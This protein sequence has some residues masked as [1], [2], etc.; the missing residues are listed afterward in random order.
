[1]LLFC[2]AHKARP[3]FERSEPLLRLREYLHSALDGTLSIVIETM[4]VGERKI[5]DIGY[6]MR[7]IFECYRTKVA[8][9]AFFESH[10][11]YVDFQLVVSGQERF[12]IGEAEDCVVQAPYDEERDLVVYVS[13][14][15]QVN[16]QFITLCPRSLAIFF[17]NDVHAGG[18]QVSDENGDIVHKCVIK[19]PVGLLRLEL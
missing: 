2:D 6:G 19:V 15:M 4:H 11:Q 14:N 13:P 3:L 9:E 12:W 1:M 8:G 5:E 16:P 10:R 7:A 18:L 17:P